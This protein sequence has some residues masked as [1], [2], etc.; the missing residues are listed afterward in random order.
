LRKGLRLTSLR[1]VRSET[2]S[3]EG[4]PLRKG[5][6]QKGQRELVALRFQFRHT[7]QAIAFQNLR[8]QYR[9]GDFSWEDALPIVETAALL[10]GCTYPLSRN[11]STPCESEC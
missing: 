3:P 8:L 2:P 10:G 4:P 1:T 9:D 5:L 7:L 6:R 11:L